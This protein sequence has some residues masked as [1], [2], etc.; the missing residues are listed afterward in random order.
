[1]ASKCGNDDCGL[2]LNPGD[3][4]VQAKGTCYNG[5]I[6]PAWTEERDILGEWHRDCFREF[7]LTAQ[8]I[9]YHCEECGKPILRGQT[10]SFACIGSKAP[11]GQLRPERRGHELYLIR[12]D[13]H[14]LM[15]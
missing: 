13:F 1:M 3:Q 9:P 11:F 6:T 2:P 4:I 12:H 7:T 5:H 10:V 8:A 15:R 14:R